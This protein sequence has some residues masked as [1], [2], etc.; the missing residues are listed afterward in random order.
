MNL[1]LT[2]ELE[3][4]IEAELKAGRSPTAAEFLSKA[5]QEI[6]AHAKLGS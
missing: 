6:T 5:A 3:K 2:P 1:L 4:L